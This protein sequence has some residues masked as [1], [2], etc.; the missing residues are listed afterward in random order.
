MS[1]LHFLISKFDES[2]VHPFVGD[3]N[4]SVT[5]LFLVDLPDG[6]A[7]DT[8][9]TYADLKTAKQAE[10]VAF[11]PDFPNIEYNELDNATKVDDTVGSHRAEVGAYEWMVKAQGTS[12]GELTTKAVAMGGTPVQLVP[13]FSV[14]SLTYAMG[15]ANDTQAQYVEEAS[16]AIKVE[17]STDNGSNWD[18]ITDQTAFTSSNPSTNLRLRFTNTTARDLYL[19]YYAVLWRT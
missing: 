1:S 7:I 8:P 9:A 2:I 3:V 11:Y 13:Y 5:G 19:G 6:F 4:F 16:S 15:Q 10:L 17:A 18:T 14:Y 12:D